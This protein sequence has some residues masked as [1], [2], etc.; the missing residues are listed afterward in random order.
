MTTLLKPVDGA[1][2]KCG[3]NDFIL[4]EDRTDYSTTEWNAETKKFEST[5]ANNETSLAEDAIRFFCTTCG[6]GHE[7]PEELT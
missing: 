5:Y 2:A 6:S 3:D 4:A 1:C 7:V